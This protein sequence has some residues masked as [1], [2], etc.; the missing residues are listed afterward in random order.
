MTE[1]LI[2]NAVVLT[3]VLESDLGPH[4][5][6]SWFRVI[7]PLVSALIII[8][9]FLSGVDVS[10]AGLILEATCGL[11][12]VGLGIVASTQMQVYR[13][14]RTMRPVTRAGVSYA[15]VWLVVSIARVI[16][17]YG[18]THWFE[19]SLGRWMAT[20]EVTSGALTDSL[21]F[22]ALAMVITRVAVMVNRSHRL[23]P[24]QEQSATVSRF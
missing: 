2:I 4:R 7:R 14:R 15:A 17:S 11:I 13:S 5:K 9:F 24:A 3:V 16:F 23:D 12:G 20:N 1:S 6:I 8:P 10:G 21:I 19:E 18:S 22:M